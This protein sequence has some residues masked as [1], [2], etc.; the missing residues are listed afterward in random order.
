MLSTGSKDAP[1]CLLSCPTSPTM[2]LQVAV[3]AEASPGA[4]NYYII[5]PIFSYSE[6]SFGE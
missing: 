1:E 5:M 6:G 3:L 4:H 2:V